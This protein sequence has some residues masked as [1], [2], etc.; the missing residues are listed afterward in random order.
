MVDMSAAPRLKRLSIA[1]LTADYIEGSV[2]THGPLESK[3]LRL[4]NDQWKL[5]V[6]ALR[7]KEQR[8][9]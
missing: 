2:G 5:I 4:R 1:K 8:D 9:A 7:E 6:A 3:S